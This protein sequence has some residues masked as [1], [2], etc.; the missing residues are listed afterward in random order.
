MSF[1]KSIQSLVVMCRRLDLLHGGASLRNWQNVQGLAKLGPVDVISIGP[2]HQPQSV[3]GV[4]H[5]QSFSRETSRAARSPVDRLM[6]KK[7]LVSSTAHPM[8]ETH[9]DAQVVEWIQRRIREYTYDLVV[10]E[11]L[12]L[13]RY[14]TGLKP[15]VGATIFDAHNVESSLHE[16]IGASNGKRASIGLIDRWKSSLLDR[17]L[18]T[19]ER[20]YGKEFDRIWACSSVDQSGFNHLLGG[21]VPVDV[22]PNS[23]DVA[24]YGLSDQDHPTENWSDE[25]LTITYLGSYSYFPNEQAALLLINEVLPILREQ[26]I[27][28]RIILIGANPTESMR[29]AAGICEDVMITGKVDSILPYMKQ[30]CVVVLPL[31][32]GSGTRLKIL[33]AFACSRPVISTAKGVEGIEATDGVHLLIRETAAEMATAAI[34]IWQDR[35]LRDKLCRNA[36]ELVSDQYS[37][38]SAERLIRDSVFQTVAA[39]R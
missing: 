38:Q 35:D 6:R 28:A 22:I 33:E 17:R 34:E 37:L 29:T 2:S 1:P 23:I 14:V 7:W 25:A 30:P 15:M 4:R 20:G 12:A 18:V 5:Y 16:E 3:P 26:G 8:L 13:A 19:A 36:L 39:N 21:T 24:G 10:V 11:E 32:L 31:R 27:P 9:Y